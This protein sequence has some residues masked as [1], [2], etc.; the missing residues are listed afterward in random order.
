MDADILKRKLDAARTFTVTKGGQSLTLRLPTET[1]MRAC[2]GSL[3]R[4]LGGKVSDLQPVVMA[5]SV[6]GWTGIKASDLGAG[7]PDTEVT[8]DAG[9]IDD[10][11][12][13]WP[14]LYD[15]AYIDLMN[16]YGER[17]ERLEAERKNSPTMSAPS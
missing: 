11:F 7:L 17:I 13:R 10:V 4:Y 2:V 8:F 5:R 16:R 6:I 1:V 15:A 14:D 12:N 3:P 9:L